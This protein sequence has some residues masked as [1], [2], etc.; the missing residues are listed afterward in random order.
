MLACTASPANCVDPDLMV[1]HPDYVHLFLVSSKTDQ[2]MQGRWVAIASIGGRYCLVAYLRNFLAF[3][4]YNRPT[5]RTR[6]TLALSYELVTLVHAMAQHFDKCPAQL[7][8]PFLPCP[9]PPFW[10]G[11][12]PYSGER[13][14]RAT[15]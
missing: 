11:A 14:W 2:F 5:T 1:F 13:V 8:C 12:R 6:K 9:T 4:G 7:L 10:R 15:S 3:G